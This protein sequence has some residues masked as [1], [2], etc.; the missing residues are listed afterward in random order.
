MLLLVIYMQPCLE[1]CQ[2]FCPLSSPEWI[3]SIFIDYYILEN[4]SLLKAALKYKRIQLTDFR[5]VPTEHFGEKD[6]LVS[7]CAVNLW[8]LCNVIYFSSHK[9]LPLK[10][11][12][13]PD[14]SDSRHYGL[15][16]LVYV[17]HVFQVFVC[18]NGVCEALLNNDRRESRTSVCSQPWALLIRLPLC[19]VQRQ[20]PRWSDCE[21]PFLP[22]LGLGAGQLGQHHRRSSGRP[23]QRLPGSEDPA[24][25][26]PKTGNCRRSG[27]DRSSGVC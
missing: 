3:L 16:L 15:L 5:T 27:P 6:R 20:R 12:Y 14:F 11:S 4:N 9:D 23:G 8:Q 24:R 10:L 22:Q 13:P 21:R 17:S 26:P 1:Y 19:F 25:G 18:R 7:I 2:F